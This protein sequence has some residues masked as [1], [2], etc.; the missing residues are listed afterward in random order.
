MEVGTNCE[1]ILVDPVGMEN[2]QEP[3]YWCNVEHVAKIAYEV[4]E[5]YKGS[6]DD[7]YIHLNWEEA[8][9]EIKEIYK[10]SVK[11]SLV[12]GVDLGTAENTDNKTS[13]AIFKAI[14]DCFR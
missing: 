11:E 8:E 4:H 3:K 2:G 1:E 10:Q 12:N 5:A 9:M 6:K 7:T 14:V 13:L